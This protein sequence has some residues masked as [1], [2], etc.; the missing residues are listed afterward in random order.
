MEQGTGGEAGGSEQGPHC[1]C[2][3]HT[4]EW[5]VTGK[6]VGAAAGTKQEGG[7]SPSEFGDMTLAAGLDAEA[8]GKKTMAAVIQVGEPFSKISISVFYYLFMFQ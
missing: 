1:H 4:A 7:V 2:G 8:T 3:C 6:I 5:S